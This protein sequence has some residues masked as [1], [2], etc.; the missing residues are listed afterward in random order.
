MDPLS[1][2]TSDDLECVAPDVISLTADVLAYMEEFAH[3]VSVQT[4]ASGGLATIEWATGRQSRAK[5]ADTWTDFGPGLILAYALPD[6]VI[7]HLVKKVGTFSCMIEIPKLVLAGSAR[8]EIVYDDTD[9]MKLRLV[10]QGSSLPDGDRL[11]L[12]N[13]AKERL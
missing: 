8:G 11:S 5:D 6:Q 2:P 10:P 13:E 9:C 4:S 12:D 3:Q 7:P 1:F